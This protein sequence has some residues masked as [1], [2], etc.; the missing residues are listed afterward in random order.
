V[1]PA[2][3][4][5]FRLA[6]EGHY[7]L[8]FPDHGIEFTADRLRRERHELHCELSVACGIVGARVIDGTLS[9]GSFNVSSPAAAQQRAKLLSERARTNGR[10]D[11]AGMLEELRQRVL[12][13]ERTGE[14]SIS[15][16]TVRCFQRHTRSTP[17]A[18]HDR[19]ITQR[20]RSAMAACA[21]P[22]SSCAC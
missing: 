20:F 12:V 18:L 21:N 15:L 11:W 10:I 17:W 3:D 5:L 4:G 9:V 14:P 16:R 8:A 2:S 13:A 6:A 7:T 22:S 19:G 1:G